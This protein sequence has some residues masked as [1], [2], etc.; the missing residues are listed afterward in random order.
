[1]DK[2][3]WTSSFDLI[4]WSEVPEGTL[5]T[6]LERSGNMEYDRSLVYLEGATYQTVPNSDTC[7]DEE[8]G[9]WD[10]IDEWVQCPAEY[11]LRG[12]W[13]DGYDGDEGGRLHH[14]DKGRYQSD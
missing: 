9:T 1:M 2:A 14:I 6:G 5:I 8:W 12:L 13:R 10:G 11:A 3:D 7:M 4:G